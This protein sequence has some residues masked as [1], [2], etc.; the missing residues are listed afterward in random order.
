MLRRQ[1][2]GSAAPAAV[3]LHP[4]LLA[5]SFALWAASSG[6]ELLTGEE[7]LPSGRLKVAVVEVAVPTAADP[8]YLPLHQWL[9][10]FIFI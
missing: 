5:P 9:Y 4:P 7:Y 1:C 3:E 2:E 6:T 10:L 8:L